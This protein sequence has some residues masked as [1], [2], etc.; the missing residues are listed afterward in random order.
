M[1]CLRIHHHSLLSEAAPSSGAR[2]GQICSYPP[3][4]GRCVPVPARRQQR[5]LQAR[6]RR[7]GRYSIK[8]VAGSRR[9]RRCA[10]RSSGDLELCPAAFCMMECDGVTP[11]AG[12][13]DGRLCCCHP[14]LH[15][16]RAG[17]AAAALVPV[18]LD[19]PLKPA[20]EIQRIWKPQRVLSSKHVTPQPSA[21][22]DRAK[23]Y[24]TKRI[25]ETRQHCSGSQASN[26][27]YVATAPLTSESGWLLKDSAFSSLQA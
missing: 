17:R 18:A 16:V 22:A 3:A 15:G 6:R 1:S 5:A 7:Q 26:T 9:G 23:I 2:A 27:T 12:A 11:R 8:N 10:A 21:F 20:A 13:G 24:T 25:C 19:P 14:L 4:A